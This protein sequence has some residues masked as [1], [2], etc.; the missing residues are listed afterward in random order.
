MDQKN[1]ESNSEFRT[2]G[3]LVI[4]IGHFIHD[5]YTSF[6][7]P[8]LPFIIEKLSLSLTQAGFLT[9]VM[10]IPALLNPYIGKLADRI[11]VRYFVIMA[12]TLTAI[13][14]SLLGIA[15][16]YSVLLLLLF[17]AGISVAL[18]HVPAPVMVYRLSGSKTGKGMS[19]FMTGGELARTLGPISIIAVVSWLGF[20]GYYPVMLIGMSV[21]FWMY[22]KF[23]DI[24]I[25][26]KS[27]K[28]PSIRRTWKE[29]KH[30]LKPL[31][32]MIVARGFMHAAASAFLP[33]YITEKTGNLWLAGISL[34]IMEAAGVAGIMTTGTLSDK[35]G[36]KNMLFFSLTTAPLA[37][38]LFIYTGGW[39][40]Y[41]ALIITGFTLLSTTPVMLA[42]IQESA[43][44]GKSSAN[45]LFMMISFLARSA[46]VV[47]VGFTAD[48]IG[49]DKTYLISAG[50]GFLGIP[51][52]LMLPSSSESQ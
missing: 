50:L 8:L 22:I 5:I 13:P 46:V 31:T 51:F 16:S 9:T 30:I 52:I 27:E 42:M 18:F 39:I 48:K 37:L 43:R 41:A 14:M 47:I 26:M 38:L 7:A 25:K 24:P 20:D 17:T 49:L 33:I 21:S 34:S 23:K 3:V 4:S 32:A 28:N 1:N 10:Q 44:S 40:R 35:F 29:L 45:G 19:F 15:P 36:R 6:L 12:P 11:S 2:G